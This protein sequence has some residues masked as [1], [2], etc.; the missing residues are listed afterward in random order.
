MAD[1]PRSA[2]TARRPKSRHS[3]Q[4][5]WTYRCF[6]RCPAGSRAEVV[7]ELANML[8]ELLPA[9]PGGLPGRDLNAVPAAGQ[10]LGLPGGRRCEP[11]W[12]LGEPS[13]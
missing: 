8:P 13:G 6:G 12:F 10:R 3:A 7:E 4:E 1:G 11:S 2:V 9:R 5:D